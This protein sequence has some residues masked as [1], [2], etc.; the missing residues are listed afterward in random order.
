MTKADKFDLEVK[1]QHQIGIMNVRKTSSYSDTPMCYICK[2]G[3]P[4][5]I[6]KKLWA[7]HENMSK[8][9]KFDL[10]V[11]V[12]GRIWIMKVATHRT[13]VI[14]HVPNMVS[15]CESKK[16]YGLDTNLHRQTDGQ[17]DRW[18]DRVIPL[19]PLNFGHDGV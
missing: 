6:Q 9:Y 10:K 16:S 15:Q 17:T 12:Q 8:N 11:K 14:H 4:M 7:G 3:K 13:M 1:G 2:Y 19:Y 18:T 5:S